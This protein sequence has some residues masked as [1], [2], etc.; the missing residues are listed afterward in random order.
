MTPEKQDCEQP[1]GGS[2]CSTPLTREGRRREED[3]PDPRRQFGPL[4]LAA[5]R[6]R[7][8][9]RSTRE[10]FGDQSL[11]GHGSDNAVDGEAGDVMSN[12]GLKSAYP[13]LGPGPEY[14]VHL[15]GQ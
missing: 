3:R 6:M 7:S 9:T 10:S 14:A 15:Q 2:V 13:R 12:G 4:P 5:A 1:N 8:E 11:P